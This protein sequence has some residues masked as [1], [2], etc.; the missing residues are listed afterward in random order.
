MSSPNSQRPNT[1]SS[2]STSS[3]NA[4][5][6]PQLAISPSSITFHPLGSTTTLQST[7]SAVSTVTDG[8]NLSL[9]KSLGFGRTRTTDPSVSDLPLLANNPEGRR[10]ETKQEKKERKRQEELAKMTP[11]ELRLARFMGRYGAADGFAGGMSMDFAS[12][13][14]RKSSQQ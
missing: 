5:P 14:R 3:P 7:W 13:D 1:S 2:K 9:F 12:K 4:I 8:K 10:K 11:E 6:H